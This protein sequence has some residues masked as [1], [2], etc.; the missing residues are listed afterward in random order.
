MRGSTPKFMKMAL[1]TSRSQANNNYANGHR[2]KCLILNG[3]SAHWLEHLPQKEKDMCSSLVGVI[4]KSLI[5]V[6]TAFS[7]GA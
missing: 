2:A 3:V 7:S 1:E 5:T 4:Q 6:P